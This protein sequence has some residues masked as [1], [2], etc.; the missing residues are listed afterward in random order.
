MIVPMD[1]DHYLASYRRDSRALLDAIATAGP[2][3]VVPDCPGWTAA[4]LAWHV[5]DVWEWWGIIVRDRVTDP[6][7]VVQTTRPATF[8]EVFAVA[9]HWAG[10]LDRVLTDTDPA[11]PHWTW[12]ADKTTGFVVRRM[13]QE[14]AVHR[15]DAER[16]A[17]RTHVIDPELASD[18]VD[19]F[20]FAFLKRVAD[21]A[22]PL[23]GSVHLHCTDVAGEWLVVDDGAGGYVVTREHAKGDAAIRGTANDL[24]LV[25]WRR[26]PLDAV[27]VIGDRAVAERFIARSDLGG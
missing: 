12:T 10:E 27:E 9:E 16:A 14:T 1:R 24:L 26:L 25:L 20:L 8:E 15:L 11:T 21:D 4:D 18:G 13:A 7:A 2:D 23:A 19:E 22:A 17:G 3:A 5:A 6:H